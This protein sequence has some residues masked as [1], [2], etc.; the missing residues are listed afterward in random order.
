MPIIISHRGNLDGPDPAT[1]NTIEQIKKVLAMGFYCE[2]DIRVRITDGMVLSG[3]DSGEYDIASL[4]FEKNIYWHCKNIAAAQLCL[5]A[6][7]K[8]F[9]HDNDFACLTSDKYIWTDKVMLAYSQSIAVLPELQPSEDLSKAYGICT[10]YP[11]K[12]KQLYDGL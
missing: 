5:F 6:G 10:D 9:I 11:L 7:L 1:E 8:F 3:H 2:V 4:L 12:Y